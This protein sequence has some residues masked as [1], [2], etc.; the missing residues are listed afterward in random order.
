MLQLKADSC[1]IFESAG[2]FL[3]M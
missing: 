3:Q 1:S 2:E